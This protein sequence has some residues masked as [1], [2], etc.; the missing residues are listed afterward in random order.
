[1]IKESKVLDH[2]IIGLIDVMG[3]DREICDAARKSYGPGTK[4]ISE[5]RTLIRYM[6]RHSH[7]SPFEM[8]ELKFYVKCPIY[9]WRQWIRTRTANVNELSLRY[10]VSEC[11]FDVT[12]HS[13]MRKQSSLNKQGGGELLSSEIV[14]ELANEEMYCL[15]D[16]ENTYK[17]RIA[18]GM[19]R[20]QA[21]KILPLS[22][23]TEAYWK[24]DLR[25]LLN[26]LKLRLDSHAQKEIRLYAQEMA[27]FVKE[28]FPLTWEAFED[29]QLN[30]V[31]LSSLDQ[32][33][34]YELN[35]LREEDLKENKVL[36]SIFKNEREKKEFIDKFTRLHLT[37]NTE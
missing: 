22:L 21:R 9:V 26:F 19:S 29:Y 31:T 4:S 30:A 36:D 8:A 18:E 7:Y 25:N 20:E 11:E 35:L 1:M 3:N 13:E 2:G 10:S 6:M 5:D 14:E 16:I 27:S 24:I 23:Y 15:A 34:L 17:R 37:R 28:I 32:R 33:A 12:P